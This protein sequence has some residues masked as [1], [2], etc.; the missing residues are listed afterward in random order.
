M[1]NLKEFLTQRMVDLRA[2]VEEIKSRTQ[3][4]RDARD[5]LIEQHNAIGAQ[6][7]TLTAEIQTDGPELLA[8]KRELATVGRA[9]GDLQA[10]EKAAG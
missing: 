10:N 8:V 6:I 1:T 4:Q 3:S 5:A 9:I 7:E 2:Q